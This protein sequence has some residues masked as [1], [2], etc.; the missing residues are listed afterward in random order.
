MS[1]SDELDHS[2]FC[3][4]LY[5]V[6]LDKVYISTLS[7]RQQSQ[8]RQLSREGQNQRQGGSP[9]TRMSFESTPCFYISDLPASTDMRS[10]VRPRFH[11]SKAMAKSALFAQYIGHFAQNKR[12][13]KACPVT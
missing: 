11:L 6:F 1:S 5:K 13:S 12:S 9:Y 2:T 3:L 10:R 7:N 4:V 8:A